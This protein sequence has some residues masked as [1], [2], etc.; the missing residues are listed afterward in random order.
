[1]KK[2]A[3]F[4]IDGTYFRSHLYWETTL[5]LARQSKLPGDINGL[6]LELYDKW[7][8]RSHSRAFEDFDYQSVVKINELL[9]EIKP[10][11]YDKAVA[12]TLN[13]ILDEVYIFPKKLKEKLQSEGY[14]ILAISGSRREEVKLFCEHHGFDD[15]IGQTWHRSEDGKSFTGDIHATYKDKEVLL[16]TLVKK[17][18]LTY[19][20]SYAIGDTTGDITIL[21]NVAHP[22]AFNP[23]PGLLTHAQQR[24]WD[25]V[26]ERKSIAYTLQKGKDGTYLLGST[27]I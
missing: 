16:E 20:D 27:D 12:D 1:M 18:S 3:V 15:W 25:I 23:N 8:K 4:D 5:S 13:P 9:K 11:D 24:G 26:L 14:M 22:I 10:T 7:K 2:F 17:H 19:E 21:E 6:V